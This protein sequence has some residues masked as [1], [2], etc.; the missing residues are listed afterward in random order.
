MM[1]ADDRCDDGDDAD[2]DDDDDDDDRDDDDVRS[3]ASNA[4]FH[5]WRRLRPLA[6]I[7]SRLHGQCLPVNYSAIQFP[8]SG[9]GPGVAWQ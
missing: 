9:S 8:G 2:D 6:H 5:V 3:F 1:M 4:D 7:Q